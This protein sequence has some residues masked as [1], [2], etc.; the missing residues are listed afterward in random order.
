ME[1]GLCKTDIVKCCCNVYRMQLIYTIHADILNLFNIRYVPQHFLCEPIRVEFMHDIFVMHLASIY[2]FICL[3]SI[4]K[5]IECIM[6]T[7]NLYT[8]AVFVHFCN[9]Y[10]YENSGKHV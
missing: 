8:S 2:T 5:C 4:Y 7:S 1:W 3:L 6:V 9:T 10:L